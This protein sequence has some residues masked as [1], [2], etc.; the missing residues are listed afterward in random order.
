MP[1]LFNYQSFL[2][3]LNDYYSAKHANNPNFNLTV[4]SKKLEFSS[5]AILTRILNGDR[6]PGEKVVQSFVRYFQFSDDEKEYFSTLVR[7]EKEQDPKMKKVYLQRIE[8]IKKESIA[9]KPLLQ[10][11]AK[12]FTIWG[13]ADH[14]TLDEFLNSFGFESILSY[15]GTSSSICLNGSY[16]FDS[17]IGTYTQFCVACYVKRKGM[18]LAASEMFFIDLLSDKTEVVKIFNEWGSPYQKAEMHYELGGPEDPL[19]FKV[20]EKGV[21]IL[22][23]YQADNLKKESASQPNDVLGFNQQWRS[24]KYFKMSFN[25]TAYF[26]PFHSDVDRCRWDEKSKLGEFLTLIKFNPTFWTYQPDFSAL[27]YPSTTL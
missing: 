1:Q 4:W 26:R 2:R 24:E 18:P 6:S 23:F 14:K 17:G 8:E 10:T 27:I 16:V 3:F 21:V 22:E 15:G 12:N 5:V 19:L 7:L 11:M 20:F 9:S 13:N 25:S